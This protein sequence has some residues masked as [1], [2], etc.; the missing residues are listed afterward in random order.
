L[1]GD[2]AFYTY[3]S[4]HETNPGHHQ[5]IIFD[6]VVTNLG[7]N[8]NRHSGIFTAPDHGVYTLSWTLYCT[9]GGYFT[10]DLVVNSNPAAASYC[11]AIGA[12]GLRHTVGIVVVEVNM[13]DVVYVRTHNAEPIVGQIF[14]NLGAR[15][16]FSGWKLF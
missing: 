2:V 16:T 4:H 7:G 15:T 8:Y 10:I 5:T 1:V 11:N 12:N 13:S 3:M 14:S 9:A 6:H